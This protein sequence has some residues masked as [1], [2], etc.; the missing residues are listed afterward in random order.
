MS[1]RVGAQHPP[2]AGAPGPHD[3][4]FLNLW[5][6]DGPRHGMSA[7]RPSFAPWGELLDFIPRPAILGLA[8]AFELGYRLTKSFRK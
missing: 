5:Q 2:K 6:C 4:S 3:L 8:F 1:F 7:S